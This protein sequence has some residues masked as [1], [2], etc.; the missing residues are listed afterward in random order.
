[1]SL[2]ANRLDQIAALNQI[3]SHPAHAIHDIVTFAGWR[4][5]TDEDVQQHIDTCIAKIATWNFQKA[6]SSRHS[7]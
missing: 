3:E 1:M 5:V 7:A 4:G 2:S 6:Q